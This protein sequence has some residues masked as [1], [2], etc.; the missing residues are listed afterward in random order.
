MVGTQYTF[1]GNKT[2]WYEYLVPSPKVMELVN[3]G[4]N[5]PIQSAPDY[6]SCS[7][8]PHYSACKK[9]KALVVPFH[10]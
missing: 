10:T 8:P 6:K 4:A 2:C 1:I 3:G 7:S 9:S 5:L